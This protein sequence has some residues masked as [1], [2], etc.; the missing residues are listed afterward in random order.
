MSLSLKL[1]VDEFNLRLVKPSARSIYEFE[2]YR[3]DAEHLMLY[4]DDAEM[5]EVTRLNG[6]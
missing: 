3:L 6:P 2:Q 1:I 4:R 5:F